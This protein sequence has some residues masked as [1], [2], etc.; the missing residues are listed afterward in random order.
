MKMDEKEKLKHELEQEHAGHHRGEAAANET[1]SRAGLVRWSYCKGIR[2]RTLK[3]GHPFE[4]LDYKD[5]LWSIGA[6]AIFD[7]DKQLHPTAAGMLMFGDEYFVIRKEQE[8]VIL[9]NPGYIRT[10]KRQIETAVRR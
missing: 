1:T 2:H 4:R 5:Y 8:K 7:I 9:E 3:A 10:G 6:A